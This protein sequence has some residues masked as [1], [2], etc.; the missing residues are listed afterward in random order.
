MVTAQIKINGVAGSS[1]S[2]S[3]G[4]LAVLTN[5]N[6][7][8][9]TS[10]S[11]QLVSR[12]P[13]SITTMLTPAALS[14]S[15]TPDVVGSY[16]ISLTIIGGSGTDADEV[17][18][19]V[20]TPNLGMRI[21]ASREESEFDAVQGWAEAIYNSMIA[22]DTAS[23]T[24]H[25]IGGAVHTPSTLAA[26]NLKI[27]DATIDAN[28]ATRT[29]IIHGISSAYHSTTTIAALNLKI[30]D[31][32]L[33]TNTASRPPNG[34]AT[35]DLSGSYPNPTVAR[36][37]GTSVSAAAPNVNDILLFTAGV[38]TPTAISSVTGNTLDQAYDEG[39]AGAGRTI[40]ADSGA[41]VINA[42]GDSA[43]EIDG[44][45]SLDEIVNPASIDGRGFLYVKSDAGDAE[46]FYMD[47]SGNAVQI[48][49]D[50]A[51]D[52]SLVANSLN[53]AYDEGGPGAGRQ[54]I[55]D[56]GSVLI[57]VDA[58][59]HG[60]EIDA[61]QFVGYS[62]NAINVVA[63]GG[64]NDVEGVLIA[65]DAD[66]F[67]NGRAIHCD[68]DA[69][70]LASGEQVAGI[71]ST[72]DGTTALAGSD[73]L[74]FR[75]NTSGAS[76]GRQI[77]IKLLSANWDMALYAQSG[78]IHLSDGYVSLR[79]VSDPTTLLN[80]GSIYTKN[81]AGDTELYY[82]DAS[83]NAVKITED[84]VVNA[85]GAGNKLGQAYNQGGLGAGRIIDAYYGPV[86]FNGDG[87]EV[88]RT[89]GA[90][91]LDAQ[92]L[93]PV[94]RINS[95]FLYS[96]DNDGY[97]ELFYADDYGNI[98]QITSKGS[99][100][101]IGKV[102]ISSN[103]STLDYLENKVVGDGAI[104]VI[105]LNDGG[106]E[107]LQISVNLDAYLTYLE[108]DGYALKTDLNSYALRS[109][110]DAYLTFAE[111]DGYAL[112]TDLNS[113]ALRSSLDAYLTYLEIDGYAKTSYVD[114]F[115]LDTVYNAGGSGAGRA[116]TVDSGP[117]EL[118]AAGD[119]ALD[120]DGYIS[121]S[122]IT[123]PVSRAN[124][125]FLY[126]KDI[127]G[128]AELFHLNSDGYAAQ[129][130]NMG[131]INGARLSVRNFGAV[132][133]GVTD[134]TVAIKAAFSALQDFGSLE[135]PPGKYMVSETIYLRNRTYISIYGNNARLSVAVG[136]GAMS[137]LL[138]MR[139]T[140]A[141]AFYDL[142]L[143]DYNNPSNCE[144]ALLL[145]RDIGGSPA[146]SNRFY[147]CVF[148]GYFYRSAVTCYAAEVELFEGCT[149]SQGAE[150]GY[151]FFDSD[152]DPLLGTNSNVLK[153]F[154]SCVFSDSSAVS[155]QKLIQLE[156]SQLELTFSGCSIAMSKNAA[157]IDTFFN[158]E[159][160]STTEKLTVENCHI[161]GSDNADTRLIYC[162]KSFAL[163][164]LKW[165]NNRIGPDPDYL[166]EIANG[167]LLYAH[168][169]LGE[170]WTGLTRKVALITN[171]S[172]IRYCTGILPSGQMIEIDT[173][174]S[175]ACCLFD[176]VGG[177]TEF[178]LFGAG[179]LSTT[180][181]RSDNFI[182]Q[183]SFDKAIQT[184][185]PVFRNLRSNL[186][187]HS[188]TP[189]VLGKE[190]LSMEEAV[191]PKTI[192]GFT[193][194]VNGQQVTLYF[195]TAMYS[196]A[197]SATLQLYDSKDWLD[198][199]AKSTLT[200]FYNGRDSRW[201]EIARSNATDGYSVPTLDIAY[202]GEGGGLGRVITADSGPVELDASGDMA[203]DI[204]GYISLQ[205]I[206]APTAMLGKGYVY[207]ELD[208]E[209]SGRELRYMDDEGNI[210]DITKDGYLR[211]GPGYLPE[212]SSPGARAD[213]GF[214][215]SKDDGGDTELFYMD[216]SGNATQVTKDGYVNTDGYSGTIQISPSI[217][218]VIING[219]ITNVV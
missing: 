58:N 6:N 120:L 123:D 214:I 14:A 116:I 8:G 114:A 90:I 87:Y 165:L 48:T 51:I 84:G 111:I 160:G 38:W 18:G 29:P 166:V 132:G 43:L 194:M 196:I 189:S 21:P 7:T 54:I 10:W 11:W 109:S 131:A 182:R 81:D 95:G 161:E 138:D 31:A 66:G 56:S 106:L 122:E 187:G 27:S 92:S 74:A 26:L 137:A 85:S 70:A 17:I 16:L 133:D 113:Y 5:S 205:S 94:Q 129:I 108:I 13:G 86:Y 153:L 184:G 73:I 104:S 36:I 100:V 71:S 215:Y 178:P 119:M 44:Y 117:V 40:T 155:G 157:H 64:A 67:N 75:G 135:F 103:D 82:R 197:H 12:P 176:T 102:T 198:I 30:T 55:A 61:Y 201:A 202:N 199:P 77:G 118:D 101:D 68:L 174:A 121:L 219:L 158:L 208:G 80:A 35:G 151:A 97:T 218:F 63:K 148:A 45:I 124:A 52:V 60:L 37:R 22:L 125:G 110:L 213:V 142:Q 209:I 156:G 134:D 98:I 46:L 41:V 217:S 152:D 170:D 179:F 107:E 69:G 171:T 149:F 181:A 169:D 168:F 83:G 89:N 76:T 136:A 28:T 15:F 143:R 206:A 172:A 167:S 53:Q 32:N 88:I 163:T 3:T 1:D 20:L 207:T 115:T 91:G 93:I 140:Q 180:A 39:G 147:N 144:T 49:K 139:G 50:G 146:N 177:T 62:S 96:S 159:Y 190:L 216:D 195:S 204:D 78:H 150:D 99:L 183:A 203:F 192:T 141:S 175:Y 105:T 42:A 33:D 188:A 9:V 212:I 164:G 57:S 24:T 19:A 25:A 79:Q 154:R 4:V 127:E 185:Q 126:D 210:T 145:A 173:S 130:T 193:N 72:V 112:K 47:D 186:S 23:G 128:A 34:A 65:F 162:N 59:N 191:T 211:L 2:L 200:L